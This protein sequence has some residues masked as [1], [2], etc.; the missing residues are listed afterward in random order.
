M[1]RSNG[2]QSLEPAARAIAEEWGVELGPRFPLARHAFVAPAGEDAV[3]KITPALDEEADHEPFALHG[4]GGRGAAKILRY[5]PERRAMLIERAKPGTDLSE[6]PDDEAAAIAVNVAT[7]LW[8]PAKEPYRWIG[9]YVPTWLDDAERSGEF[10]EALMSVAREIYPTMDVGRKTLI[11]GDLHHHN[12]LDAGDGRYVAIDP[13]PMC[14]DPEFDVAPFLWNPIGNLMSRKSAE[15][16]LEAFEKAG[17]D[18]KRMRSWAIVRGAYL[19]V[20]P[21][22]AALLLHLL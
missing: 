12:I 10:D 15:S 13:K 3:L 8:Q 19:R 9:D 21:G 22:A 16:W 18:Q 6:L 1:S 4:W 20:D 2:T 11:H 7:R 14:G 17:L 5:D